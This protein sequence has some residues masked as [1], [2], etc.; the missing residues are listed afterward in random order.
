LLTA[1]FIRRLKRSTE[2][3]ADANFRSHLEGLVVVHRVPYK[4][5]I[6]IFRSSRPPAY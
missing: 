2:I 3:G 6:V 4:Y 1:A 5:V